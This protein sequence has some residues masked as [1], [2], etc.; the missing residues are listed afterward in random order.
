[1]HTDALLDP[2]ASI[3][4]S[5][6]SRS[7]LR[8]IDEEEEQEQDA[9]RKEAEDAE[10]REKE[11]AV[12]DKRKAKALRQKLIEIYK[13]DEEIRK[14][15]AGIPKRHFYEDGEDPAIFMNSPAKPEK[16]EDIEDEIAK[17]IPEPRK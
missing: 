8:S 5:V 17:E 16:E 13:R 1:M 11:E 12:E 6:L 15:V 14:L 7:M 3:T 10:K 9:E 4:R 2:M